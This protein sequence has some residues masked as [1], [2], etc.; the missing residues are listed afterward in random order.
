MKS[1]SYSTTSKY[2]LSTIFMFLLLSI[3]TINIVSADNT[4]SYS[5]DQLPRHWNV[6]I[7]KT[8]QQNKGFRQHGYSRQKPMRSRMWGVAPVA[9]QKSRRTRRPEYNTNAY[10]MNYSGR[11]M[12]GGYY[13]SAMNGYGLANPYDSP[14]MVPGLRPH[15]FSH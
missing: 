2:I 15:C 3:A 4:L 9:E 8:Q 12:Y 7:N 11:N 1:A 5:P 10:M 14:L 13:T 6:L